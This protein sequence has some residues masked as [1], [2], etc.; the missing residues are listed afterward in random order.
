VFC[1]TVLSL[2][3]CGSS[4]SVKQ[5]WLQGWNVASQVHQLFFEKR[6]HKIYGYL[7]RTQYI[8][9]YNTDVKNR[10]SASVSINVCVV[11]RLQV[12]RLKNYS[13]I[14]VRGKIIFSTAKRPHRHCDPKNILLTEQHRFFSRGKAV[15]L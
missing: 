2:V 1:A 3:G 6:K 5:Y 8:I 10:R 9:F 13:L 4:P 14:A 15:C 11:T 7:L 12:G